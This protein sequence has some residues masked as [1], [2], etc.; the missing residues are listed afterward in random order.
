MTLETS[1]EVMEY[2]IKKDDCFKFL[3]EK[4]GLLKVE[5]NMSVFSSLVFHLIGQMLSNKVTNILW[6]RLIK[7]IGEDISPSKILS[8]SDSELKSIGISNA[9]V[10]YIKGMSKSVQSGELCLESLSSYDDNQL[11][12]NLTKING[13]GVWTAEMI[14]LFCFGRENIFSVSDVALKRGILKS[15]PSYKT[16]SE[17]RLNKLKK[18]YSPFCSYA[19]IYFYKVNDDSSFKI[20]LES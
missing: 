19:S 9:K 18:L 8:I 16:L 11:I 13:I 20:L 4:Y 12:I 1:K 17:S 5:N 10:R 14:A 2:L 6:K 15:H 7:L 3:K